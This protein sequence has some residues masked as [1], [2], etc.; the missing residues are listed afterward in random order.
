MEGSFDVDGLG[1]LISGLVITMF[2]SNMLGLQWNI[3]SILLLTLFVLSSTIIIASIHLIIGTL[4]FW[5]T[6]SGALLD[7]F[8]TMMR[9]GEYPLDIYNLS[10]KIILTI[11]IPIGFFSYYPAQLFLGKGLWIPMAYLTPVV[12]LIMYAIAHEFW[13]YG[14]KHY[15]STGS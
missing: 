5:V 13:D 14:L 8:Y 12:A 11:I 7:L 3:F 15:T 1:D 10:T 4:A 2:A 9:F 6:R